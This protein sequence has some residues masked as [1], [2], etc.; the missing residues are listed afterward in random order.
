MTPNRRQTKLSA[1]AALVAAVSC[2]EPN[3]ELTVMVAAPTRL[4]ATPILDT[5]GFTCD[6][7][8]TASTTGGRADE[9]ATWEGATVEWREGGATVFTGTWSAAQVAG[10]FLSET[11]V[12]GEVRTG[13][14]FNGSPTRP[15]SVTHAFRYRAPSGEVK[16][17]ASTTTCE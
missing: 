17:T 8:I 9:A 5:G 4:A 12:R 2:T 7:D 1:L 14:V 15:F 16:T 13:R 6:Y 3:R 11:I 10:F